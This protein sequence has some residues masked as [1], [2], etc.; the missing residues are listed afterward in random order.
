MARK[1]IYQWNMDATERDDDGYVSRSQKKRDSTALQKLGEELAALS[2][3]QRREM[4]LTEDLRAAFQ[5]LERIRDKEGRRRQMQYV[6]RLMREADGPAIRTALEELRQGRTAED[7]LFHQ[8]ERLRGALLEA[9]GA[10]AAD[11]LRP[12][13]QAAPA[14]LKLAD[15]AR[16]ERQAGLPPRASRALFRA[17]REMLAAHQA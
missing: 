16:R 9:E 17:V 2:A 4:P 6:G 15:E 8:A 14:L 1:N 7:R 12:W 3:A 11:L 13:P 10:A 5:E